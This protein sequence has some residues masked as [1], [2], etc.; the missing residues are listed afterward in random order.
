MAF[1]HTRE[2]IIKPA[3]SL[4]TVILMER[5]I[6]LGH[7]IQIQSLILFENGKSGTERCIKVSIVLP[8]LRPYIF[9]ESYIRK[10]M[11]Q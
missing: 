5:D 2:L 1:L 3:N 6:F 7:P 4:R 9:F 8:A 11:F 10:G